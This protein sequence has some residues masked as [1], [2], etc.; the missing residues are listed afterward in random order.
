[1]CKTF[2]PFQFFIGVQK[3]IVILPNIFSLSS[4][5]F[6]CQSSGVSST[7]LIT[8]ILSIISNCFCCS[9]VN[10]N[11]EPSSDSYNKLYIQNVLYSI[12]LCTIS[13]EVKIQILQFW[14]GHKLQL[15]DI[16]RGSNC[17]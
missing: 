11:V 13:Q 3:F 16:H 1:M 15:V 9:G 6:D 8:G 2:C 14:Q 4:C 17:I 7:S 10:C 12:I 5:V